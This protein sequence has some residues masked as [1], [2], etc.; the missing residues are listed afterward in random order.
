MLQQLQHAASQPISFAKQQS[1]WKISDMEMLKELMR[2]LHLRG[3]R[4]RSLQ[5]TIERFMDLTT[6]SITK[7][8]KEGW[9]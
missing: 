4:E 6:N 3:I 9:L 7:G 8:K 1:W 5:K 2:C